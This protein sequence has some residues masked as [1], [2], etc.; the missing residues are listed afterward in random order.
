MS[1]TMAVMLG[2]S[3]AYEEV[4]S[5]EHKVLAFFLLRHHHRFLP[6]WKIVKEAQ[7]MPLLG[8]GSRSGAQGESG[9]VT[10]ST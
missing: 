4:W 1:L 7:A 3:L 9:Q 8:T 10:I 2:V 5:A 6:L